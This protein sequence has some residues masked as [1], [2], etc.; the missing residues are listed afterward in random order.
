MEGINKRRLVIRITLVV[1]LVL[2]CFGLYYIGKEH[3]VY[4]DNKTVTI[5]GK[6]YAEMEYIAVSFDGKDDD[7]VEYF[8]GDRD[9]V[10]LRGPNHTIKIVVMDEDTEEVVKTVERRLSLGTIPGIMVSLPA[11]AEEAENVE[12]PLPHLQQAAAAPEEEAPTGGM[13]AG[14]SFGE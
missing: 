6:E 5:D 3:D 9:V 4:I 14:P 12:L 7:A 10:K 13:D 1:L 11:I 8:A 2:L